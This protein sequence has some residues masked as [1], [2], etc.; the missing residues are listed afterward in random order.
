MRRGQHDGFSTYVNIHRGEA[1]ESPL[2]LKSIVFFRAR[3]PLLHFLH[4]LHLSNIKASRRC[5][6]IVL[7]DSP[8]HTHNTHKAVSATQ[9]PHLNHRPPPTT[10]MSAP[11]PASRVRRLSDGRTQKERDYDDLVEA[12][13]RAER[14]EADY[15]RGVIHRNNCDICRRAARAAAREEKKVWQAP[16]PL[17]VKEQL[18]ETC[19]KVKKPL[20]ATAPPPEYPAVDAVEP[21][22]TPL[23]TPPAYPG[24][25]AVPAPVPVPATITITPANANAEGRD[26][27]D[28][29]NIS[30]VAGLARVA[31]RDLRA[32]EEARR[33]AEEREK[34]RR[35]MR[36]DPR[37]PMW[38]LTRL[39]EGRARAIGLSM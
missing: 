5:S 38:H 33:R 17:Y 1:I 36:K 2:P 9:Q 3:H 35:G 12:T 25:A 14:E 24:P 30:V 31:A 4:S 6:V 19:G 26:D 15:W 23:P 22:V 8:V 20:D 21:A 10:T 13:E 37:G 34:D 27:R 39:F 29:R 11:Q 32:A 16:P 28:A 7:S 18:C